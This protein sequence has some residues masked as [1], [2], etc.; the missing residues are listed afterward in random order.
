[1]PLWY[2]WCYNTQY[3][4]SQRLCVHSVTRLSTN[5][6][7]LTKSNTINYVLPMSNT[8][9]VVSS[10]YTV[11]VVKCGI[12]YTHSFTLGK[13]AL[14]SEHFP[15]MSWMSSGVT[16]T[17]SWLTLDSFFNII[18][19]MQQAAFAPTTIKP[20][21]NNAVSLNFRTCCDLMLHPQGVDIGKMRISLIYIHS[22]I[23]VD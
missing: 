17:E 18:M 5:H 9:Q 22:V 10:Q 13:T 2:C 6:K 11:E 14:A 7:S 23:G 3:I 15:Q 4:N 8:Y 16:I 1:M 19:I 20:C 21:C 12:G